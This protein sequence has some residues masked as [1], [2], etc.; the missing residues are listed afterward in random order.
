LL[1]ANTWHLKLEWTFICYSGEEIGSKAE[2]EILRCAQ[3]GESWRPKRGRQ[4]YTGVTGFVRLAGKI[5]KWQLAS[6]VTWN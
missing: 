1:L 5:F 4:P 3:N 2:S 6:C